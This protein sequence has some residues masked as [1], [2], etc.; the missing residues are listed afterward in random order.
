M[1][2]RPG[3]T[4]HHQPLLT[5]IQMRQHRL[6]LGPKGIHHIRIDSRYHIMTDQNSNTVL[7]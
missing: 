1:A 5:L 6:E 7:I 4:G 2:K 3:L